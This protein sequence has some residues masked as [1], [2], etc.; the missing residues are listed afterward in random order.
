VRRQF[1]S[2]PR[3]VENRSDPPDLMVIRHYGLKIERIEQL[4]L[5]TLAP[6]HHR[7][8]PPMAASKQRNHGSRPPSI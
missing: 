8:A 1:R 3:E 4:A 2:D 7:T 5:L 6:S